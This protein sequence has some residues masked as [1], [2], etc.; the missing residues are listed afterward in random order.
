[1]LHKTKGHHPLSDDGLE[2]ARS[3][4]SHHPVAVP[5]VVIVVV[6][7]MVVVIP[8]VGAHTPPVRIIARARTAITGVNNMSWCRSL[9]WTLSRI[10]IAQLFHKRNTEPRGDTEET[11]RD[12]M[13]AALRAATLDE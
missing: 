5:R 8:V 2:S 7:V 12:G 3:R 1:M 6:V 13:L 4:D 10:T 9:P 11:T